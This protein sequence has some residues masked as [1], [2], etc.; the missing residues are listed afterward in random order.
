LLTIQPAG[1]QLHD[2]CIEGFVITGCAASML[3]SEVQALVNRIGT[4]FLLQQ[5]AGRRVPD[6][7]LGINDQ[8]PDYAV[9]KGPSDGPAVAPTARPLQSA[10]SVPSAAAGTVLLQDDLSGTQRGTLPANSGDPAR[11]DAGYLGGKY[12]IAVKRPGAMGEVTVPGTYDDASLAIDVDMVDPTPAHSVQ[13]ACRAR[14]AASQYRFTFRPANGE[15]LLVRW[16]S[17]PQVTAPRLSLLPLGLYSPAVQQG[18][19]T[20][21]AELSCRRTTI[22]ARINGVTVASVSDNT[23][24]TGQM[25]IAVSESP[26]T[27]STATRP[28]ARF[29]NLV[30]RQE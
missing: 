4:A 21:H 12:E 9:V 25:L 27:P 29:S 19:A 3:Q 15:H 5:V 13:L 7:Q 22:T 11:F 14:D 17:I 24:A 30:V 6:A 16:L 2:L 10:P 18:S 8:T 20:N 1:H 23:F 26:G 28:V